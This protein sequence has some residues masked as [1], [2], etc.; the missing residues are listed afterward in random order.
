MLLH[1]VPELG[2]AR[3]LSH[4]RPPRPLLGQRLR[5]QRPVPLRRPVPPHLPADRAGRAWRIQPRPDHPVRLPPGQPD[6]DLLPVWQRQ[7]PPPD[8]GP[9]PFDFTPPARANHRSAPLRMPIA[10]P[11]S[12][13]DRP[14]RTR[15]QNSA[16]TGL[17]ACLRPPDI[18][19]T[20]HVREPLQPPVESAEP[21]WE[22]TTRGTRLPQATSSHYHFNRTARQATPGDFRACCGNAS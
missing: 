14:D 20:S 6:R 17:G 18:T 12:R 1:P 5:P 3:E 8:T 2:V 19:T 7:I 16:R 11:A 10:T 9:G 4:L 15:S 13:G 22:P 21:N